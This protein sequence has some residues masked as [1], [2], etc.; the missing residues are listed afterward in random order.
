[1]NGTAC[2]ALDFDDTDE[3]SSTHVSAVVA[4]AAL[5]AGEA[6]GASGAEVLAAY[7]L[8]AEAVVH[9][10]APHA[11]D[12][13]A[14]GFHPTSVVGVVGAALAASLLLGLDD[15]QAVCALGVAGSF[16]SGLFEYLEDGSATKPLHAGWAAQ[17]G[18]QAARLAANGATGPA[19]VLEGR[20]GLFAAHAGSGG[21]ASDAVAGFGEEWRL[22]GVAIKLVPACHFVHACVEQAAA[23]A[24]AEQIDPDDIAEIV[25]R[26]PDPGV[27]IVLEPAQAKRRPATP[28]DAKF[29]LPFCVASRLVSGPLTLGSFAA[30][31][32]GDPDVLAL[33]ARVRSEPWGGEPPP[34]I[35]AG[36]TRI[37]RRGGADAAAGPAAPAGSAARPAS[38]EAV[39]AKFRA[40]ASG[41][42]AAAAEQASARILALDGQPDLA[43]IGG[44]LSGLAA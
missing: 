5:A 29:S 22:P 3:R 43:W 21:A 41:L 36:A 6:T 42:P 33:A 12:L 26:I 30:E 8:G 28:Y 24:A 7:A 23:L 34:S 35:F 38:S 17:A 11:P 19:T 32:I 27:P 31:A 9:L 18:I 13:Y 44:L 2:H 37:R 16:A 4:P 1:M 39:A 10:G 20:F 40:C 25:V 15:V 14:R